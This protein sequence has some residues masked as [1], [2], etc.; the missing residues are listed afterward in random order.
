MKPSVPKKPVKPVRAKSP[1]PL[2]AERPIPA[3]RPRNPPRPRDP[4]RPKVVPSRPKT[5]MKE[6]K[7]KK[8]KESLAGIPTIETRNHD[9]PHTQHVTPEGTE[10]ELKE[11]AEMNYLEQLLDHMEQKYNKVHKLD[12]A[13]AV[14]LIETQKAF[15]DRVT[16][17][18]KLAQDYMRRATT[19]DD[20]KLDKYEKWMASFYAKERIKESIEKMKQENK[21]LEGGSASKEEGNKENNDE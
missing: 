7:G 3:P 9:R 21:E 6:T 2:K 18:R 20:S 17:N 13:R 15:V 19:T 1:R 8:K 5:V 4:P 11:L 12:V 10:M 14:K 16:H